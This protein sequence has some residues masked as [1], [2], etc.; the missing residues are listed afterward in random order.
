MLVIGW[1]SDAISLAINEFRDRVGIT[2]A[3]S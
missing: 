2:V 1:C 3:V